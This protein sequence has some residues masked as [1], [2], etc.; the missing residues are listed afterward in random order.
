VEVLLQTP[1]VS[2]LTFVSARHM[3][4]PWQVRRNTADTAAAVTTGA[5]GPATEDQSLK[6]FQAHKVLTIH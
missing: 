6:Y 4:E 3:T 5:E 1:W 2:A